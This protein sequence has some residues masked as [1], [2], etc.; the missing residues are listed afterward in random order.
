MLLPILLACNSSEYDVKQVPPE[1]DTISFDPNIIAEAC[2][3]AGDEVCILDPSTGTAPQECKDFSVERQTE[4]YAQFQSKFGKSYDDFFASP[5]TTLI[6]LD[7]N[8]PGHVSNY[9]QDSNTTAAQISVSA[10]DNIDTLYPLY[11]DEVDV[12]G[13]YSGLTAYPNR[14]DYPS[15][16][17]T[18]TCSAS[19]QEGEID[20]VDV[21]GQHNVIRLSIHDGIDTT[22]YRDAGNG[23]LYLDESERVYENP[24]PLY[25]VDVLYLLSDIGNDT[26]DA[27]A[28]AWIGYNSNLNP[29][30][31]FPPSST[32]TETNAQNIIDSAAT[33]LT[34]STY[35]ESDGK[36]LTQG[37]WY[38]DASGCTSG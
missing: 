36:E 24:D 11:S 6:F 35:I 19:I 5:L 22:S 16:L 7:Q 2:R 33:L 28:T 32:A 4:F 27:P 30:Y 23:Y 21:Q 1:G 37:L 34:G 31:L 14:S 9:E 12:L 18:F 15:S 29:G 25:F 20:Q 26:P 13:S 3:P 17:P 38:C 8:D 10:G